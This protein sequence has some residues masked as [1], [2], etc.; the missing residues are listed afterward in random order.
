MIPAPCQA[1]RMGA[2]CR[3]AAEMMH[4]SLVAWAKNLLMP[5]C[6]EFIPRSERGCLHDQ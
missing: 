1:C 5:T 6:G 2:R 3:E 4:R